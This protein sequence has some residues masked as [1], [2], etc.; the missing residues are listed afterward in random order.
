MNDNTLGLGL[1][2]Q[3]KSVLFGPGQR[4]QLPLIAKSIASSVLVVTDARM[5]ASE[6]FHE[7]RSGLQAQ[8]IA[9]SVY[10]ETEP[11]LP[12][13]NVLAVVSRYATSA[14]ARPIDAVIG[15]GGGSCL[16]LAKVAAVALVNQH[17]VRE[18][19][20]EFRVPSPG[21]PVITVPTTGGTGAEVTCISVVYDREKGMKLGIASPHLE[22]YAA[23]IDPELTLSCPRGLTAATGADA[24]S[25]LIEAFTAKAKNPSP[26][27]IATKLYVGKNRLTDLFASHGLALLNTGL[28][29]VVRDLHDVDARADVMFAA[30]CAGMAINT[31]G[32]AGAHA[33]QSPMATYS[34]APHGFGVGALLPYIMRFNLPAR[35]DAFAEIG[36][37]FGVADASQ[38]LV[39]QAHAAIRRVE[40]LLETV[41][42][43]LDLKSIGIR[44]EHFEAIASQSMQATRLIANNPRAL[45]HEAVVAMLQKGYDGDRSWWEIE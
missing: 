39:D 38:P 33:I 8:G 24:L 14:T 10:A 6:T 18:Y 1:L 32:T 42:A 19:Y 16:D 36:R 26:E 29:G 43:P 2:R 17:D 22:P 15:I 9:V 20:G 12:R 23:I 40:A 37:I 27:E 34:D 13:E 41:G 7:I 28:P 25:H 31:T 35:V 3:P 30:Y 21:L 45:T 5:A 11:D 4:R 44:P